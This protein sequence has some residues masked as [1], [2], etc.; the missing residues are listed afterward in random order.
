M[1][2]PPGL[3]SRDSSPLVLGEAASLLS[4]EGLAR[5]FAAI[6][7]SASVGGHVIGR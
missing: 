7:L 3:I 4:H 2:E 5:T 1:D 6:E